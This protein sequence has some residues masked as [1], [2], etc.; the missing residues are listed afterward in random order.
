MGWAR[1]PR[2]IQRGPMVN[3]DRDGHFLDLDLFL[4]GTVGLQA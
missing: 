1:I 4:G 2:G 3:T